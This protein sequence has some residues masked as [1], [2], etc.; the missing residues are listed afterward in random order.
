MN[1]NWIWLVL[2]LCAFSYWR[3]YKRGSGVIRSTIRSWF[4]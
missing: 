4:K 3:G 2:F 1:T